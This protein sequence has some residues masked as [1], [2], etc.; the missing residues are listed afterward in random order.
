MLYLT[1]MIKEV[2]VYLYWIFPHSY[3]LETEEVSEIDCWFNRWFDWLRSLIQLAYNVIF[4]LIG[5][6]PVFIIAV[7]K[8]SA[9][10]IEE[11]KNRKDF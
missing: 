11:Y 7:P 3:N 6:E 10:I 1:N 9:K 8:K 4:D 5:S 2:R